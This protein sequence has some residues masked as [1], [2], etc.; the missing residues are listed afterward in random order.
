MENSQDAKRIVR[1]DTF[2][3]FL[4]SNPASKR[5]VDFLSKY[6]HAN[7][8]SGYSNEPYIPY[9]DDPE[10]NALAKIVYDEGRLDAGYITKAETYGRGCPKL[11]VNLHHGVEWKHHDGGLHYVKEESYPGGK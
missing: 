2:T 1:D 3:R 8:S 10:G 5:A 7:Y 6:C 4:Y 9:D 11:C